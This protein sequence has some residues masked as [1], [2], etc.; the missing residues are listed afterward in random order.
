M[1]RIAVVGFGFMGR[2][3]YGCWERIRGA[4]VVAVCTPRPEKLREKVEGNTPGADVLV[5]P[6]KIAVY[7]SVGELIAAGKDILLDITHG[8][9]WMPILLTLLT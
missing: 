4:R 1:K 3:H 9:R 7:R 2:V 5:D 8:F 6:D